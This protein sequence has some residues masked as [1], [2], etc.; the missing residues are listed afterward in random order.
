MIRLERLLRQGKQSEGG[1]KLTVR[2][3]P[4]HLALSV[5]RVGQRLLQVGTGAR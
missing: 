4:E 2:Q 1:L 3:V 5:W